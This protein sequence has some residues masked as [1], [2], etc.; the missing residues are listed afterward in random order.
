MDEA[1]LQVLESRRYRPV[2]LHGKPIRVSYAFNLK[3]AAP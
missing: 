2:L 1:V 3:L